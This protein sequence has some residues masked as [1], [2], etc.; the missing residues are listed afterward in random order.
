MKIVRN[1]YDTLKTYPLFMDNEYLVK[2]VSII[3]RNTRTPRRGGLTNSHHIIPK[4]WFKIH[5]KPI[6]NS[7]SNLVNLMYREHVL[8]HYYLCLCTTGDLLFANE[9][10]LICL[11]SRKKLNIVDKQLVSQLPLYNNIYE[12]YRKKKQSNYRLYEDMP[13]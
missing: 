8:A 3:E 1:V 4:S 10:A 11:V 5:K 6:D 13:E 12:D 9:L 2:Y 7:L